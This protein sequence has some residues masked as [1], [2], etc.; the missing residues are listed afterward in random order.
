MFEKNSCVSDDRWKIDNAYLTLVCQGL[1]GKERH[2]G[3][4]PTALHEL[5][6][7]EN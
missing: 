6:L 1:Y 2:P 4:S 5:Q 3:N 7:D